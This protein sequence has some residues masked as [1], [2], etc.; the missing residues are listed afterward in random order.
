MDQSEGF[1]CFHE[2]NSNR[3]TFIQWANQKAFPVSKGP[4]VI[5]QHIEWTNQKASPVSNGPIV[6]TA[7]L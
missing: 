3:S 1:Y 7:W 6:V 5:D 4:I 2:T